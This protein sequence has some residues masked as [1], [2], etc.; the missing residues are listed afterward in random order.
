MFLTEKIKSFDIFCDPADY[1]LH[2]NKLSFLHVERVNHTYFWT[3]LKTPPV[4]PLTT[5]ESPGCFSGLRIQHQWSSWGLFVPVVRWHQVSRSMDSP[6]TRKPVCSSP[7]AV[8]VALCGIPTAVTINTI[9]ADIYLTFW[10]HVKWAIPFHHIS[11]TTR[12]LTLWCHF[13][14]WKSS[15]SF[16]LTLAVTWFLLN[17]F[18]CECLCDEKRFLCGMQTVSWMM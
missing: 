1:S 6:S 3:T 2:F 13:L 5:D 17:L 4:S 11:R 12:R 7:A 9:T 16:C 8:H 10:C 18:Q 15:C 14:I